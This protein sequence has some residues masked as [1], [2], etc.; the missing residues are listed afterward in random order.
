MQRSPLGPRAG[1]RLGVAV[2]LCLHPSGARAQRLPSDVVPL[3][4]QLTLHLDVP[5]RTFSGDLTIDLR[6][7]QPTSR[8]VMNAVDL[9]VRDALVTL[10]P[11]RTLRP[12]VSADAGLQTVTFALPTRL[13]SGTLKLH[14]DY[15]GRLDTA[16]RGLF[17]TR[18]A[19]G[20]AVV[21]TQFEPVDARRAFPC[22]D[23]PAFKASFG[24][25]AVVDAGESAIANGRL[26][27]DTPG[28]GPGRHTLRF[29]TTP[30][31]SPY[32]VALAV[33]EFECLQASTD[34][35]PIRVCAAPGRADL[36]HFALEAAGR[37]FHYFSQYFGVRYPF[38]KLDLV[39]LPDFP[40]DGMENTGAIFFGERHLLVDPAVA[41]DRDQAEVAAAVSHEVAHQWVGDLVT[42]RWWDDL[43]LNEGL[44]TW[45]E[46]KPVV[47][48]HP[49]WRRD[50][51]DLMAADR[52][53]ALDTLPSTHAVR[54]P[55]AT[56]TEIE[57]AFDA[58]VYD[59]AGA[60]LRMIEHYAGAE[61]LR[62]G[63]TAYLRGHLYGNAS[64]EDLWTEI[65]RASGK[66]VD[67]VMPRFID[68]PGLPLLGVETRCEEPGRT[69]VS[70]AQWRAAPGG[71]D[72]TA[73]G[74]FWSV[75]VALRALAREGPTL[76]ALVD[77]PRLSVALDGC[78]PV[79]LVDSGAFGYFYSAYPPGT[80]ARLDA[81][82]R[83]RLSPAERIR[84]VDDE[85]ALVGAG[86][87][88][89]GDYLALAESLA[90][91]TTPEVIETLA[92]GLAFSHDHLATPDSR[93]R[94][95]AWVRAT[96]GPPCAA[97][98][99]SAVPGEGE[100]RRE[101]RAALLGILGTSGRDP[102]VLGWA[103]A[104]VAGQLAGAREVDPSLAPT[105]L[106]LAMVEADADLVDRLRSAIREVPPDERLGTLAAMAGSVKPEFIP[107]L[108]ADALS[109]RSVLPGAPA[110]VEAALANPS[111]GAAALAFLKA[112][113]A[114]I[115]RQTSDVP[116]VQT[117]VGAAASFCDVAGRDDVRTLFG[118]KTPGYPRT[119][120]TTLDQI[121]RCR[122]IRVHEV[123]H[124]AQWLATR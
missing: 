58:M 104:L 90:M 57:E 116:A 75:P 31:M 19:G 119:L 114:D 25:S 94:F 11:D 98:G 36:G 5:S 17:L 47:A 91:D 23:E 85:W 117:L 20:R 53:M 40:E 3:H 4:Y 80:I 88:E 118:E 89:V 101:L 121:D 46:S 43:W 79:V 6:V 82:S 86:V 7:D 48:W 12:D 105:V 67:R 38:E 13:P 123:P 77:G 49:E 73:T 109:D 52:A 69:I 110:V 64:A 63:V 96:F 35:I 32:L 16:M 56:R 97:V 112:H 92:L 68:Q 65:A 55:I 42:M 26:I 124:L 74:E 66:P 8:I 22:F 95:E 28:P 83:G 84:L 111:S 51:A 1:W 107:R 21:A 62:A 10:P 33:G 93:G 102:R 50:L 70:A 60:V 103:R 34:G 9:D 39:A 14:V 61:A 27:S 45:L 113:W 120:Q 115:E 99:W 59:K 122:D 18:A 29:A 2:A 78:S 71:V 72:R 54:S 24:V 81:H 30:R 87:H 76:E 106:R 108:L 37:A 15:D 100:E 41:S 44:A